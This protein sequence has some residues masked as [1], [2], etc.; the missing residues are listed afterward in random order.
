MYPVIMTKVGEE[1]A[2][3]TRNKVPPEHLDELGEIYT[4]VMAVFFY[5]LCHRLAKEEVKRYLDQI[6]SEHR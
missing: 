2:Y 4:E 5:H 1:F 3:G 6:N